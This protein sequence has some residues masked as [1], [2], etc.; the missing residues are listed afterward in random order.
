MLYLFFPTI[1]SCIYCLCDD[2]NKKILPKSVNPINNSFTLIFILSLIYVFESFINLIP[3]KSFFLL[4]I[5]SLIFLIYFFLNIKKIF[6]KK[7]FFLKKLYNHKLIFYLILCYFILILFPAF[8]EDTLRYHLPIAKL[9]NEKK[10]FDFYWF[11]HLTIGTQEF[12]NS[13]FL[14]FNFEFGSSFLN[15]LFIIYLILSLNYLNEKFF[16]KTINPNNI[17]ILLS[18]PYF[19]SLMLSQKLYLIACYISV[20]S[21]T[22]V[23][24]KKNKILYQELILI[25]FSGVFMFITKAI[26]FPYII[27][28]FFLILFYIDIKKAISLYFL[29]FLILVLFYFPIAYFKLQFFGDPLLPMIQLNETNYS[30]FP[31]YKYY[32]TEMQMD[33]TQKFDNLFIKFI[34][35]PIKL[36]LPLTPSDVL[37]CFG[38]SF[39]LI[40]TINY[41][42]RKIIFLTLFM[43][44]NIFV[45][46][47]TQTR[48]FLP[49]LVFLTIFANTNKFILFKILLIMQSI[50]VLITLIPLSFA[51]LL[52]NIKII[53]ND[54]II[55]KFQSSNKVILD[56]NK[57]TKDKKVITDFNFWYNLNNFYPVYYP[58]LS[59]VQNKNIYILNRK[60]D[61]YILWDSKYTDIKSFV[62]NSLKCKEYQLVES[63]VFNNTRLFFINKKSTVKLYQI[64]QC[65]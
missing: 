25:S 53:N 33:Y 2:L 36:I 54:E 32:L 22:Y 59:T 57:I 6:I 45:L 20:I 35:T 55:N 64:N 61:D 56:V 3:I 16:K 17:L 18:A 52:G 19:M 15:F 27:L 4:V 42:N 23:F 39:L 48:W 58:F 62:K 63:Y 44:L 51:T 13:F 29:N 26:F 9:I 38:A 65:G 34:L 49:L 31:G 40:F 28:F 43:F 24:L 30:W 47:N 7:I 5:I 37:K 11:D 10:F 12:L 21:I 1:I 46:L 60:N 41:K 50:V 14:K 8:D